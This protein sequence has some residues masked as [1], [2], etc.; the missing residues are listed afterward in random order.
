[1]AQD[2]KTIVRSLLDPT[3]KIDTLVVED[4][5]TGTSNRLGASQKGEVTGHQYQNELGVDYPLISINGYTFDSGEIQLFR[6]ED[7]IGLPLNCI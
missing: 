5:F 1:M 7:F 2:E 4:L 3:I 6:I